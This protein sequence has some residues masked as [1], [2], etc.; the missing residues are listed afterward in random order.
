M[1]TSALSGIFISVRADVG[2]RPYQV[3]LGPSR[4]PVPGKAQAVR[5]RA[6]LCP[7]LIAHVRSA[8]A[9]ALPTLPAAQ[10]ANLS[11]SLHSRSA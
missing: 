1:P 2:I 3:G 9:A 6:T 7:N 4:A 5:Y 8:L 10:A 11:G